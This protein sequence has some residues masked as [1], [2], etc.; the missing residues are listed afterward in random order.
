M[1]YG[2]RIICLHLQRLNSVKLDA[3]LFWFVCKKRKLLLV[4]WGFVGVM[5]RIRVKKRKLFYVLGTI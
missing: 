2:Q 5:P 1:I 4:M 3:A